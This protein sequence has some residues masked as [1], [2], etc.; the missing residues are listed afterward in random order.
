MDQV[1][2]ITDRLK[3]QA[4]ERVR[5]RIAGITRDLNRALCDCVGNNSVHILATVDEKQVAVRAHHYQ[6]L[7]GLEQALFDVWISREEDETI[8]NFLRRVRQMSETISELE[9]KKNPL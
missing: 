5:T 9:N 2:G 6:A 3:Q 1:K 7:K 8:S 4:A